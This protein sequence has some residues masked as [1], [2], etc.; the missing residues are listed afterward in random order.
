MGQSVYAQVMPLIGRELG[1]S[2]R[3]ITSFVSISAF[4]F[5]LARTNKVATKRNLH[6]F[7]LWAAPTSFLCLVL[8]VRLLRFRRAAGECQGV[9]GGSGV[10]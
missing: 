6:F 2:V 10:Y 9:S 7:I 1:F 4:V 3:L 8:F 5:L